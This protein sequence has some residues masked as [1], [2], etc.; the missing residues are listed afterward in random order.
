MPATP[1]ATGGPPGHFSQL[2]QWRGG[3]MKTIFEGI[4]M[5]DKCSLKGRIAIVE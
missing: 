1:G 4:Q 2:K 5:T 3:E